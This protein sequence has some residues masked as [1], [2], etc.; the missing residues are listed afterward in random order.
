MLKNKILQHSIFILVLGIEKYIFQ[1]IQNIFKYLEIKKQCFLI[2]NIYSCT[3]N[4][5]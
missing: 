2:V 3:S 1:S 5:S 4:I